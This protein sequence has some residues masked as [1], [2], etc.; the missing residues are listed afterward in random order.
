MTKTKT[1]TNSRTTLD[2]FLFTTAKE[3]KR[4]EQQQKKQKQKQKQKQAI[5]I[6]LKKRKSTICVIYG[7]AVSSNNVASDLTDMSPEDRAFFD[8]FR[9]E[10]T[11]FTTTSSEFAPIFV[12][13]KPQ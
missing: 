12:N 7:A 10:G 5:Q 2:Y 9:I 13:C 6:K 3:R 4:K 1:P 11:G 8:G